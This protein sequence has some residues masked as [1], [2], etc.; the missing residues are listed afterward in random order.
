MPHSTPGRASETPAKQSV[1]TVN[2]EGE[3]PSRQGVSFLNLPF[4]RPGSAV[5]DADGEQLGTV[6]GVSGDRFHVCTKRAEFWIPYDWILFAH[7]RT[8]TV[9]AH[10]DDL[11]R[12]RNTLPSRWVRSV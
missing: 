7:A 5:F 10:R 2:G 4:I 12:F 6:S 3:G 9:K 11:G 8:V 1:G